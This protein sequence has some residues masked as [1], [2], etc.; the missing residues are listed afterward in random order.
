MLTWRSCE[1]STFPFALFFAEPVWFIL[2]TIF[3]G[4]K[5]KDAAPQQHEK[6]IPSKNKKNLSNAETF[7]TGAGDGDRTRM[8]F[9][10][11]QDF[12]SCAS[13]YSATPAIS[14][15]VRQIKKT[16]MKPSAL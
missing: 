1:T 2:P 14:L 11:P 5:R 4:K 15:F 9:M 10:E 6:M 12:K 16:R 3:Y 7:N 13:A 8:V